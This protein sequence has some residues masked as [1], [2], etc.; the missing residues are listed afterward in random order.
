MKQLSIFI[1][2][3]D[4]APFYARALPGPGPLHARALPGPG[5]LLARTLVRSTPFLIPAIM[6]LYYILIIIK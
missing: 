4:Q 3:L 2:Y 1:Q 6:I 5:P